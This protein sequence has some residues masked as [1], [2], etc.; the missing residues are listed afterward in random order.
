MSESETV[1]ETDES[2]STTTPDYGLGL[3]FFHPETTKKEQRRYWIH[4][5]IYVVL[6]CL[7]VWPLLVPFNRIE[8]YVLSMPFNMFWSALIIGFVAINTYFLFRF[9]VGPLTARDDE[10]S[11]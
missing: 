4:F 8:P 1:S 3:D 9:D 11:G 10:E 2:M 5:S 7:A 6:M